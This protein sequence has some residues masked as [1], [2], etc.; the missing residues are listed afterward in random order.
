MAICDGRRAVPLAPAQ[1][2]KRVGDGDTGPNTGGWA[3][4]L[5]F[6]VA[7]PLIYLVMARALEPALAALRG[8]GIDYRGV[9]YAGIMLTADGPR[10]LE[11]NVRF[12]DP[13]PRWSS[14][15]D[16]DVARVLA[17]AATAG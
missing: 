3:P 4:T 11:F 1:D 5:P 15:W 14:R 10:V 8:R 17:A 6:Q 9:L 12:G 7:D 13:E 2:F 16:G